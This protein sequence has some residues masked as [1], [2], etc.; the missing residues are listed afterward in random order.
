M[1]ANVATAA[2]ALAGTVLLL[3]SGLSVI[4]A[5]TIDAVAAPAV[6]TERQGESLADAGVYVAAPEVEG[7]FSYSQD[8]RSTNAE[9]TS[10]FRKAATAMCVSLPEYAVQSVDGAVTIN[11]MNEGKIAATI[12]DL[13]DSDETVS[14]IIGCS[15]ATN[16]PGGGA[17]ANA[18]ISGIGIASLVSKALAG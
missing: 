1:K 2:S 4:P 15:C 11:L 6:L 3:G 5:S 18:E 16:G 7:Q 9:I 13:S 8:V 17:V 12:E 14:R 10:V